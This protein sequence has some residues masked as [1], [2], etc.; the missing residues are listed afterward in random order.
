M[1]TAWLTRAAPAEL[2]QTTPQNITRHIAS[3]Y[4][5]VEL[6]EEATCKEFL[7]A[8]DEGARQVLRALEHHGLPM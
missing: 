8:R 3:I 2:H 5:D 6:D 4:E 1:A 7:Q